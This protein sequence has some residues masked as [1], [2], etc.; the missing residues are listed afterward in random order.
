M[1]KVEIESGQSPPISPRVLRR[2]SRG[3][4]LSTSAMMPSVAMIRQRQTAPPTMNGYT[5]VT[6]TESPL[7]NASPPTGHSY[8][9]KKSNCVNRF[10]TK[11]CE[12]VLPH[13][14]YNKGRDDNMSWKRKTLKSI[15]R[16]VC[17][18]LC[19]GVLLV[20][21]GLLAFLALDWVSSSYDM[22]ATQTAAL[23]R[24]F[25][26]VHGGGRE[27]RLQRVVYLNN[28]SGV[29]VVH[30]VLNPTHGV[31]TTEDLSALFRKLRMLNLRALP[32]SPVSL[33]QGYVT[34]KR[35]RVGDA[36]AD[37]IE[38]NA[39]LNGVE[40]LIA[41]E[42]H[43]QAV[44]ENYMQYGIEY[45]AVMLFQEAKKP[46][47]LYNARVDE[48][49][50]ELC[51]DKVEEQKKYVR[52]R[53]HLAG[54]LESADTAYINEVPQSI[55]VEYNTRE[56]LRKRIKISEP[57]KVACVIHSLRIAGIMKWDK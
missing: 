13:P 18:L 17:E 52:S 38:L 48:I 34:Y 46:L 42:K 12:A 36:D 39:T 19:A 4:P 26:G 55:S 37:F 20:C 32:F 31:E 24:M 41:S 27:G 9:P 47:V 45:N 25:D 53:V 29:V 30:N 23:L 56:A 3:T 35:E 28:T 16:R 14:E 44:C 5:N 2:T 8:E 57:E 1:I 49:S 15:S 6:F 54:S 21:I 33:Q 22:Q 7:R 10:F 40:E 43:A 11:L 50:D 51:S